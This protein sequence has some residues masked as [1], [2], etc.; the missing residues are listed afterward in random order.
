MTSRLYGF[1][2][3]ILLLTLVF[4]ITIT[5]ANVPSAMLSTL[6]LETIYP[7]LHEIANFLGLP[8]WLSGILIDGVYRTT[9]WVVSVMLPPMA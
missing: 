3:M 7:W 2:I 5:A 1:P 6:L 9:A 8:W 4:W